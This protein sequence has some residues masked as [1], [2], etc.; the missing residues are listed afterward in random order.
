MFCAGVETIDLSNLTDYDQGCNEEFQTAM[1]GYFEG[2]YS[3]DEAIA[4]FYTA[5]VEKYPALTAPQ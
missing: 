1:K 3:K 2:T 4:A 5:V